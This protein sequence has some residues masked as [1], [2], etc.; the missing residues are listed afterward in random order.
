MTITQEAIEA[1]ARAIEFHHDWAY[2]GDGICC[3]GCGIWLE[4]LVPGNYAL[5]RS[6]VR[7]HQAQLAL[8]AALP[9][10]E[11]EI[12]AQVEQE[13]YDKLPVKLGET[14]ASEDGWLSDLQY[15]SPETSAGFE[16]VE[17]S[18]GGSIDLYHITEYAARI[19][20]GADHD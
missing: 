12:R 20:E 10:I 11:K 14:A 6:A 17:L 7:R 13:L 19:A 4:G 2:E 5:R 3:L 18:D 1:A 16:M 8:N 9:Y 15:V